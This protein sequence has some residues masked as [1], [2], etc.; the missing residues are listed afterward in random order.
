M[1]WSD[2]QAQQVIGNLLRAGVIAAAS[3]VLFG[4]ILYLV[5]HG[6]E[7]AEIKVFHGE[8]ADLTT[9]AGVLADVLAFK[10]RGII[11]L[12][13]LATIAVPILRVMFSIA[14][15]ALERDWL[16]VAITSVVFAIL[17]ATLVYS[18]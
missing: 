4:G 7:L 2:E 10:A 8:P 14:S 5:R 17:C 9:P 18:R 11:Q 13:V 3:I 16:Y 15:F 1:K 6:N 12:G